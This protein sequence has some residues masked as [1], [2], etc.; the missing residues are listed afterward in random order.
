M[1]GGSYRKLDNGFKEMLNEA[2]ESIRDGVRIGAK[3]K[4]ELIGKKD[5]E[6]MQQF[7]RQ[8]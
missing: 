6:L 8:K 2:Q 5:E 1:Q 4:Y 7:K 3:R